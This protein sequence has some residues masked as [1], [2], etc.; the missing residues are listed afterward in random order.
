MIVVGISLQIKVGK[1]LKILRIPKKEYLMNNKGTC[2]VC[3]KSFELINND[4]IP[5]HSEQWKLCKG[6]YDHTIEN[7]LTK[8]YDFMKWYTGSERNIQ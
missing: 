8:D 1:M 3:N 2:S 5:G 7:Y 6:S 4:K